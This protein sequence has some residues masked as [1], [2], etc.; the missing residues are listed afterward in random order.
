MS[1]Q[2][3]SIACATDD[4]YAPHCATMLHSLLAQDIQPPPRIFVLHDAALSAE[5]RSGIEQVAR[6]G[7]AALRW[8]EVTPEEVDG[9]PGT[10]FH[11]SCWYRVLLP[12]LLPDLS[13][14]LYID[15]DTLVLDRLE[16]LWET[17]LRGNTFGAVI[18]PLY[19]FMPDRAHELGLA[20]PAEYLNSGVLLMDLE[21]MRA[22]GLVERLRAYARQHPRNPWPEQDA[23]SVVCRGDWLALPPRWNVQSTLF[24]LHPSRL[25]FP[26][27]EV[28]RA[29]QQPGIV[30][31]I[32]PLKPW[33]YLCRHPWRKLYV[34]H[35][36]QT[37]WAAFELEGRTWKNALLRPFSLGAQLKARELYRKL[38]GRWRERHLRGPRLMRAF[39]R[40]YPNAV[41]LQIGSNDGAKHDPLRATFLKSRWTG[42]MVEPVPYVFERLRAHYGQ[43]PRVRLENVAVAARP[44]VMPFHY[45]AQAEAAEGLPSWYDELGSFRKDVVLKHVNEIPELEQRI[46]TIDVNC[47]TVE[48][49]CRRNGLERID[50]L[51]TDLEGYDYELI[52]SLDLRKARPVVLV[53]EH[54]HLGAVDRRQCREDL[55]RAGYACFEERADTWCVDTV[56]RDAR[57]GRFLRAWRRIAGGVEGA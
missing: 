25:P 12:R 19:P 53:Y 52:K 1:L 10:R 29:R 23:L 30:H 42:V 28:R 2:P 22:I 48:E 41:F 37:A 14:V 8:L 27:D 43:T 39:G 57:H 44:G 7:G 20:G 50:L 5:S 6:D 49:L 38:G 3:L 46:V 11:I 31:F 56:V 9:F 16:D 34:E 36:R 18:N 35:R 21:R 45:V 26:A 33:H 15:A 55:R 47:V 4:A 32:G 24:D 13:R 17:D 51:H 40:H 54:K